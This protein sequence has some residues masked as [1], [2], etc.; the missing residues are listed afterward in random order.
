M[1]SAKIDGEPTTFGTSGL[2]YRSNK[3]MYD[4]KT[5]SLW[6]QFTGEPVIGPLSDSGI[7]LEFFPVSLT[8]WGE[9]MEE[10]PDT[11]VLS[12]D[13]DLYP[14]QFYFPESDERA[15]YYDY[16]NTPETTFPIAARDFRLET[17]DVVLGVSVGDS[18]K[19][20]A[21]EALGRQAVVNDAVGGTEV[22][23][24]GSSVSQSSRGYERNGHE[25]SA[26]TGDRTVLSLPKELLDTTG[27]VWK[28]TEDHLVNTADES[29]KLP[30]IPTHMA[31][32]FAWFQFHPTTDLY[33]APE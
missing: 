1:Y 33:S 9:W 10:H 21:V 23:V 26:V 19:A 3:L 16:F 13:T 28:V 22:V 24:I 2:L 12:L 18:H 14:P 7:K 4:R 29:Q 11:T 5:N 15:I 8:T 32:W 25:F 30:R 6:R 17:K 27:N 31:F 20:Y